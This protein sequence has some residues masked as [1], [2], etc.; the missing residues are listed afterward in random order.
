MEEASK[1]RFP[2]AGLAVSSTSVKAVMVDAD[3]KISS[4]QVIP[5]EPGS[6]VIDRLEATIGM[7]ASAP[8]SCSSVG[9]A[10]PGVI[11]AESGRVLASRVAEI[12]GVDLVE[13]FSGHKLSNIHVDSQANAA[14]FAEM[15]KGPRNREQSF[16]YVL[17]DEIV[18]GSFILNG[19]PWRGTTGHAGQLG[20]FVVDEEGSTLDDVASSQGIVRRTR[21]RFH[22]DST[23]V[24]NKIAEDE[25]TFS[26]IVSAADAGDDFALMMFERTGKAVGSAVAAIVNLL[27][28]D[29]IVIGGEVT[30]AGG[31]LLN[32]IVRSAEELSSTSAF[33]TTEIGV[34]ELDEF[35]PAYGAAILASSR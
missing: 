10:V 6:S 13:L 29:K 35:A 17:L 24:L 3:M 12:E 8:H 32:A 22:Q 18:A 14:A 5:I 33:Q 27:S 25:I 11:D 1:S 20:A 30:K 26:D 21:T 19:E 23:S 28:A 34:S 15:A 16:Y 4:S 7:F 9:I 2:A 31:A